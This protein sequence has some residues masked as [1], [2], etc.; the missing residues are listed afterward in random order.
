M[1]KAKSTKSAGITA[2]NHARAW[3]TENHPGS[4]SLEASK[5][6]KSYPMFDQKTGEGRRVSRT[7]REDIWSVFDIAVFPAFDCVDL[8]QVT[9]IGHGGKSLSGVR[10][11]QKKVGTFVRNQ[12]KKL[13]P[14]WLG[15]IYVVGWV[16]RKHL[17]IWR[18]KWKQFD[19]HTFGGWV[20]Q[21]PAAARLP[22]R[23]ALGAANREWDTGELDVPF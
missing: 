14:G 12:Y 6:V 4:R 3:V 19:A 2:M 9:T 18:W 21:E 8:I 17:R 22:K 23:T 16:P 7:V 13:K 15:H 11:R 1:R 20:E 10:E 5:S